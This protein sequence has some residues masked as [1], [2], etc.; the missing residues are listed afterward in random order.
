MVGELKPRAH[1][2]LDNH[3]CPIHKAVPASKMYRCVGLGRLVVMH[4]DGLS[5]TEVRSGWRSE[6]DAGMLFPTWWPA[7][8]RIDPR[9]HGGRR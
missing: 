2:Y 7:V 3:Q 4:S 9:V 1:K 5:A 6:A 8:A